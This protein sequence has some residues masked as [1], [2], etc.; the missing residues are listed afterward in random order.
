M[1]ILGY[2]M[3]EDEMKQ[4]AESFANGLPDRCYQIDGTFQEANKDWIDAIQN[5]EADAAKDAEIW[6]NKL[7]DKK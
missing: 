7:P 1:G 4:D 2:V 5:V 3:S 6:A